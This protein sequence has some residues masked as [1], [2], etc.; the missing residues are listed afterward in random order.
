MRILH[1]SP[2]L[3]P[4]GPAQLAADLACAL[5]R[6]GE[7]SNTVL[8]PAN[9]LVSRVRASGA[10]HLLC[11]KPTLFNFWAE[12][13]R[14]RKHINK[15]KPDIIQVYS[16]QAAALTWAACKKLTSP[17]KPHCIGVLTGF[18]QTEL[19]SAF[20]KK[21]DTFITTSRHLR[22]HL[23]AGLLSNHRK[24]LC[25]VPYGVN[26]SLCY[27]EF[28][29]TAPHRAQW[30]SV[31]PEAAKRLTLC[32]PGAISPLHGLEDLQPILTELLRQGIPTHAYIAGDSRKADP[33]YTEYLKQHFAKANLSEHISWLGARPDMREVMCACDVTLSLNKQASTCDRAILEALSLGCPVVGYDHG[34]VGEMLAA[35][36]PEG[37]VA[38]GDTAAVADTLMQ[39]HTYPPATA[40]EIP[41][42]Y[43]LTDTANSCLGLYKTI[44]SE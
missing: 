43:R 11:R 24:E 29:H 39:W 6:T 32:I 44:L 14:L 1:F 42:P 33:H 36:L 40:E 22:K 2:G 23:L 7:C 12:M 19:L 16:A 34:I 41:Y 28:R 31:H 21:C 26:E 25:L 8:S 5:Q 18:P 4:G 27:P 3:T 17:G 15:T 20:W 38:P 30:V 10:E 13:Q 35:F 9:A 37:R